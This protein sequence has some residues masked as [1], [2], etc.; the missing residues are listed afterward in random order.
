MATLQQRLQEALANGDIAAAQQGAL[1]E[2]G[3]RG[4]QHCDLLFGCLYGRD[5][6]RTLQFLLDAAH[7]DMETINSA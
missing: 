7:V 1:E 5:P 6:P 4:G 3:C 2:G